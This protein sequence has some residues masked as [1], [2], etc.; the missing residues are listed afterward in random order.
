MNLSNALEFRKLPEYEL[1]GFAHPG[2][3]ID[4]DPIVADLY[5]ADGHREEE[6]ATTSLLFE[7]LQRPLPKNRELQFAHRALHAEQQTIVWV[8]RIVNAV[9]IHNDRADQTTELDQGMPV[10][11]V[12]SQSRHLDGKDRPDPTFANRRQQPLKAGSAD[13]GSR[14]AKIVVNHNDVFPAQV[15]RTVRKTILTA[16]A[17]VIMQQLIHR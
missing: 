8:T 16:A 3:R 14:T 1:D 17:L 15:S 6:L 4:V 10:T 2:I 7:S 11:P 5:I 12:T 13:A 9:L